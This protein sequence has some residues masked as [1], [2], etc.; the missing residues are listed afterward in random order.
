MD[1]KSL[2]MEVRDVNLYIVKKFISEEENKNYLEGNILKK[3]Y[4]QIFEE[5]NNIYKVLSKNRL[6]KTINLIE[7][8]R[9]KNSNKNYLPK[10]K[11]GI[12]EREYKIREFFT[13]NKYL[14]RRKNNLNKPYM[15]FI[16]E[17]ALQNDAYEFLDAI[18]EE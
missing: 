12:L 11:K 13:F 18:K 4:H 17:M 16:R 9:N 7:N 15:D 2:A 6:N 10:V 3:D 1:H 5:W 14:E 8:E